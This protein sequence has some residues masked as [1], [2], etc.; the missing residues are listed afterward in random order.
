MK[1]E[2]LPRLLII[3]D[4]LGW[5]PEDRREACEDLSLLD[6]GDPGERG[7]ER[8]LA[9]ATFHPGVVRRGDRIVTD[10]DAVLDLVAGGW[11]GSQVDRWA[12]I[13]LDLQFD[14]GKIAGGDVHPD[15][16]WPTET[17]VPEHGL[18]LLE[19]MARR[20]PT[21]APPGHTALPV[22]TLS[23]RPRGELEAGLNA[24][25]NR[26]YIERGAAAP[27]QQR[28]ELA[29]LLY[30][31]ALIPDGDLPVMG[32]D[33]QPARMRREPRILGRSFALLEALRSARK[34]AST[35]GPCLIVGEPGVG[36]E[37]FARYVHDLSDR[38]KRE[39]V[40]V[41][42]AAIPDELIESELFGHTRGAF[43][44]ADSAKPGFFVAANEGSIFLD[45]IGDMPGAAQ[46]K[47]LRV[48]Q[49]GRVRP[50]GS[51]NESPVDVRIIAATNRELSGR[52]GSRDDLLGRLG[53]VEHALRVPPLRAREDD[54]SVL[55]RIFLEQETEAIQGVPK[56]IA[57][58][59]YAQ[60]ARREWR[61]NN[62][63]E[64]QNLARSVAS[65]C[66]R[67]AAIVASNIPLGG[68]EAELGAAGSQAREPGVAGRQEAARGNRWGTAESEVGRRERDTTA[69]VAPTELP[70]GL[71]AYIARGSQV[72]VPRS[73]EG[74]WDQLNL[75]KRA[76]GNIVARLLST[77]L[78]ETL[79]TDGNIRPTTAIRELC[80]ERQMNATAAASELLRLARFFPD[81]C[82]SADDHIAAA[83]EWA[84]KRRRP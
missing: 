25:G 28:A 22:V 31:E 42:C 84:K 53:G 13:L 75:V 11:D 47:V 72:A 64:L 5:S 56:E 20:W 63:R 15:R 60:L 37:Q 24:L 61:G 3:D 55:F 35:R 78:Q 52:T 1:T 77:A 70:T 14:V 45:E 83:L 6:E 81:I 66:A 65:E 50:L 74:R 48:L 18:R 79:G 39:F 71:K 16:N 46:A 57:E 26:G 17:S 41:N 36:K 27:T 62:V 76:Y 59:A 29:K 69:A 34:A 54:A 80:G 68:D 33:G 40:P 9:R 49:E 21:T 7:S 2:E 8:C 38:G 23:R 82:D 58:D 43:T 19:A 51:H 67:S 10:D 44:G 73:R 4:L 32:D 12:L 30:F